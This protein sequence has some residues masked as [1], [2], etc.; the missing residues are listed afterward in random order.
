LPLFFS[1]SCKINQLW[2]RIL[3]FPIPLAR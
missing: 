1:L 2:L 3:S